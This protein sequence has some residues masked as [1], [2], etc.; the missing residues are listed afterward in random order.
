MPRR[1]KKARGDDRSA[2]KPR[3]SRDLLRDALS[4]IS[5]GKQEV[6]RRYGSKQRHVDDYREQVIERSERE[7]VSDAL[8]RLTE[9]THGKR[10][11]LLPEQRQRVRLS[12]EA[13]SRDEA[14]DAAEEAAQEFRDE[15]KKRG[16]RERTH[17]Y[18]A[19]ERQQTGEVDRT[20]RVPR[21]KG[22]KGK[23]RGRQ[24]DR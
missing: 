7:D 9:E 12:G 15:L 2:D 23:K 14:Q 5:E 16:G 17:Y 19:T 3:S 20:Y 24:Q 13:L 1:R 8:M 11:R 4:E 6:D 10:D 22:K 21:Q 18:P